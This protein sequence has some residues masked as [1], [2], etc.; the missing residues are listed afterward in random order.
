MV[1]RA[2]VEHFVDSSIPAMLTHIRM[3]Y[4]YDTVYRSCSNQMDAIVN[5]H[6]HRDI[7]NAAHL[8]LLNHQQ[9]IVHQ[10]LYVY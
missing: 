1:Y 4:S 3:H 7:L 5:G 10:V 2:T 8:L 6:T 9:N